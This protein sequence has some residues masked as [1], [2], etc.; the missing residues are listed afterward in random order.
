MFPSGLTYNSHPLACAAALATL[1]VYEEND[2]I[3]NARRMGVIMKDLLADLERHHPSVGATRSIGLFG[4]VEL[5]KDRKTRQPLAP[6]GGTS[7]EMV[8]LGRYLREEGLYTFVRWHTFFTN[9]PLCITE[10]ELR[11][12]FAMLDRALSKLETAPVTPRS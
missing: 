12:G 4:I 5:V 1:G 10:G 11:E 2:L 9:P 3:A 6:F 7:D 8:R